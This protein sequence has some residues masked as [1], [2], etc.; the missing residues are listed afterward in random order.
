M[1]CYQTSEHGNTITDWSDNC[2]WEP[3]V[4]RNRNDNFIKQANL[5]F[6]TDALMALRQTG[7]Q[8]PNMDAGH[9]MDRPER[10]GSL[11]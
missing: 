6:A 4:N 1:L 11:F 9:T 7:Q 5:G 10:G 2:Y 8:N 3:I